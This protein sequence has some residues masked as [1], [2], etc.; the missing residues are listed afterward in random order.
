MAGTSSHPAHP[1]LEQGQLKQRAQAHVQVASEHRQ[2]RY[3][4]ASGQTMPVLFCHLHTTEVFTYGHR[5]PHMFQ[6][7]FICFCPGTK[8]VKRAWLHLLYT[9]LCMLYRR[10]SF[11]VSSRLSTPNSLSLTSWEWYSSF[12]IISNWTL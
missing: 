1:L 3:F 8:P 11:Q 5:K 2:G 7:L 9:L 4:T 12:L 6:F 10:D